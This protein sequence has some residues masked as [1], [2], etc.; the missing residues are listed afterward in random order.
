ML[1]NINK[2]KNFTKSSL[3]KPQFENACPE[4]SCSIPKWAPNDPHQA[5]KHL[6]ASCIPDEEG[7][8]PFSPEDSMPPPPPSKSSTP[9]SRVFVES[10]CQ[11]ATSTKLL[12][13]SSSSDTAFSDMNDL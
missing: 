11:S 3:K 8:F 2:R 6:A 13:S 4:P 5:Q 12:F 7:F 10:F 9:R 1:G